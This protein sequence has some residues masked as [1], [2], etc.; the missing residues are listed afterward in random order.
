MNVPGK[1]EKNMGLLEKWKSSRDLERFGR[2]FD[3]LFERFGL[4]SEWF[5]RFPFDRE[6]L[7]EPA[8]LRP[9]LESYVQ[10]GKFVVRADLPG[11]DPKNVD[12][13]VVGDVLTIKGSR[14]EKQETKKNDLIRREIR[15]G[16]FERAVS[17]PEGIKAADL[18]ATYR[19]GVL[20]LTAS[21]PQ[22]AAPKEV[23]IQIEGPEEKNAGKKAEAA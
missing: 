8:T 19:D 15:Y 5:P 20:E 12:I 9:A 14:E 23:K 16:S 3:D 1:E 18:K 7:A 21:L 11:I 22:E 17:L 4:G 2:E 6:W 10:E 13:K